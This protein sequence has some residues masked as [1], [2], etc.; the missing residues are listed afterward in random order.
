MSIKVKIDVEL[1]DEF[2]GDILVTAFDGTYGGCWYWSQPTQKVDDW[3]DDDA[4]GNWRKV[5][6]ELTEEV[7]VAAID[8]Q[9]YLTVDS[10][11]IRVGLQKIVSGEV[12]INDDLLA[13]VSRSVAEN[14]ADIDVLAADCIVQAGLFG[15]LIFG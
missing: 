5:A 7:G 2:V 8:S 15:E 11:A 3:L 4:D 12:R 1:S 9:S 13:Q 14:D 6:I 10:E